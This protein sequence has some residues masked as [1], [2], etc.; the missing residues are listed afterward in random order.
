MWTSIGTEYMGDHL[1]EM[2]PPANTWGGHFFTVPIANRTSGDVFRI[3]GNAFVS[4]VLARYSDY[5]TL[6]YYQGS[7]QLAP[8]CCS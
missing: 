3:L 8:M 7:L 2:L 1:V 4:M 6:V 5:S